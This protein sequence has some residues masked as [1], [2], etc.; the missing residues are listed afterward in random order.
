MIEGTYIAEV[1]ERAFSSL[2]K[3]LGTSKTTTPKSKRYARKKS[4]RKKASKKQ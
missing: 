4:I 2:D 3:M 1:V